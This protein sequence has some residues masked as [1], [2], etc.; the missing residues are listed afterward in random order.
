MS[1]VLWHG[2]F[3]WLFLPD[4]NLGGRQH[5][6]FLVG[7]WMLDVFSILNS[8]FNFFVYYVMGSRFRVTLC[9]LLGRKSKKWSCKQTVVT[10]QFEWLNLNCILA[11]NNLCWKRHTAKKPLVCIFKI[12]L[13]TFICFYWTH[14]Q[15]STAVNWHLEYKAEGIDCSELAFRAQNCRH[16]LR[17]TDIQSTKL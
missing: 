10:I 8:T 12:V 16:R 15:A 5:N 14:M 4:M 17:W 7:L 13:D 6:L 2:R 3:V 1:I 9:G 11:T